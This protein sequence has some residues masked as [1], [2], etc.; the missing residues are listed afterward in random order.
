MDINLIIIF[1]VYL[2]VRMVLL[3][4]EKTKLLTEKMLQSELLLFTNH[5]KRNVI[6]VTYFSSKQSQIKIFN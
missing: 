3:N 5:S 4:D 6:L 1:R 2:V